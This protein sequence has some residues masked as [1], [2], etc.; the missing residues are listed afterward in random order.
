MSVSESESDSED[1]HMSSGSSSESA[2]ES[3]S[4]SESGS[5]SEESASE[6]GSDSEAESDKAPAAKPAL[7]A[8]EI[9]RKR[10]RREAGAKVRAER[11]A[12]RQAQEAAAQAAAK[13]GTPLTSTLLNAHI[14][15]LPVDYYYHLGLSS[16]SQLRTMFGDV[17][18]V[19]MSGSPVRAFETIQKAVV[20]LNIQ[21]PLGCTVSPIGKTERYSL[22][23]AG[24]VLSVSHGMGKPSISIM[25]HEITKLL[26]AAGAIDQTT[27]IRVGTS[28]G[29][30]VPPGTVI[31]SSST[32]NGALQPTFPVVILGETVQRPCKI[33]AD[34]VESILKTP[35][36]QRATFKMMKGIT[37]AT[38]DFYEGQGR[39]DG[40]IC[41]Y[42]IEDKMRFIKKAHAQ[43][44]R[45]IEMES[46]AIVAFCTK[47]NIKCAVIC[48][49]IVDRLQGDQVTSTPAQ[50]VA[51]TDSAVQVTLRFIQRQLGTK[52]AGR[53]KRAMR[54]AKAS[55]L[56]SGASVAHVAG[57]SEEFPRKH[58]TNDHTGSGEKKDDLDSDSDDELP[59]KKAKK[60]PATPA[61]S[62]KTPSKKNDAPKT[63]NGSEK[64]KAKETGKKAPQ[65]DKKKSDS[66]K[67]DA[68]QS[69]PK[70][71]DVKTPAKPA[72]TPAASDKKKDAPKSDAKQPNGTAKKEKKDKKDG[73][74]STPATPS[75]SKKKKDAP[76]T[77][78][79]PTTPATPAASQKKEKKGDKKDDKKAPSK[80]ATP[81][82]D[83]PAS[84][85]KPLNRRQKKAAS[86]AAA[87]AEKKAAED[88][89]A[90]DAK[91]IA[92]NRAADLAKFAP[93]VI[94]KKHRPTKNERKALK[95]A[96]LAAAAAAGTAPPT[97]AQIAAAVD[98]AG[99]NG[100]RKREEEKAET[101]TTDKK[102]AAKKQKSDE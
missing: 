34:L 8:E 12:L 71:A 18:Y 92:E 19:I 67:K 93:D 83:A 11:R 55:S 82:A 77:P 94:E 15:E 60:A 66:T 89:A 74:K 78:A 90:A 21:L 87:A 3:D 49:T 84:D 40:A 63:P 27:Y 32:V 37:M 101:K 80:P 95:E 29:L 35:L 99:A 1:V 88:K 50:L 43:G 68:A 85:A 14:K 64:K 97:S 4:G 73:D 57:S 65:S 44:V 41:E 17:R 53:S 5:A 16:A 102:K 86:D 31:V 2:S 38:D 58:L 79:A 33:D 75:A 23:K 22:Y 76:A 7:T 6:S 59:S 39:L 51:Y 45:N 10:K 36:P 46:D 70:K 52:Q 98:A 26:A 48:A 91:Q 56:F 30:G 42:N 96:A 20:A 24:P 28:G 47:L 62:V 100:K 72:Q 61:V 54:L 25:L 9:D 69:T 81:A 13:N